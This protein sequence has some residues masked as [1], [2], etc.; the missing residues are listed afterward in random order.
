MLL[1]AAGLLTSSCAT[2]SS[3]AHFRIP[4]ALP[5][6]QLVVDLD[7]SFERKRTLPGTSETA[8][9]LFGLIVPVTE[10]GYCLT[11]AHNLGKGR[12]MPL[13]ETQIG[14]HDFGR[15]YTLLDVS[16][17]DTPPFLRLGQSG[18]RIVTAG[19]T[20]NPA[21]NRFI[22]SEGRSRRVKMVLHE[23]ESPVFRKVRNHPANSD[24]VLCVP[25]REIKVWPE[26]DLALVKVPFPTPSH[27]TLGGREAALGEP[28]MVV[29]NPGL[30]HG[31]I[32]MVSRRIERHLHYPLAFTTFSPLA[33]AHKKTG[34]PGDSGG[35]VINRA[36]ELVGINLA[37]FEGGDRSSMDLA[38]SI[39][40]G[41]IVEAIERSRKAAG[42]FTP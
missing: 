39:R 41:P 28:L 36:G 17:W 15:A 32:N 3:R 27:F 10:D 4:D 22:V 16:G 24:A 30:H 38:V 40:S 6:L 34:K 35:P 1:A 14:R 25:V 18:G 23:L 31:T 19:K 20:G 2:S 21:S 13:F 5:L 9:L 33:L 7:S 37:T 8:D 12:S 29:E 11:A 26:D 42:Y